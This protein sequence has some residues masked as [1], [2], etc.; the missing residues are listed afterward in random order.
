M[1]YVITGHVCS[2]KSTHVRNH[3]KP[4]DIVI[5]MDRIALALSVEG[6]PHHQYPQ[7]VIDVARAARLEAMDAAVRQHRAGCFDL[8]IV[9]AYPE[10]RDMAT[11]ARVGAEVRAMRVDVATLR[12]RAARERPEAARAYL[13]ERLAT[14]VGSAGNQKRDGRPHATAKLISERLST[15]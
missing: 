13:E 12:Q 9:H 6:T 7:H 4:G 8:W 14:G 10:P 11:Y 15:K 5:D 1:I 3:A 2:G